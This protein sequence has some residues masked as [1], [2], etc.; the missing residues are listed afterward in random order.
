MGKNAF[1]REK[2]KQI[3]TLLMGNFW[4]LSSFFWQNFAVLLH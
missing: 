3:L 4:L 1:N 2:L